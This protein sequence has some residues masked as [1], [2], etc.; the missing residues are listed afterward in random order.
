M[1]NKSLSIMIAAAIVLG[2][3]AYMKS[4]NDAP[5]STSTSSSVA[6]KKLLPALTDATLEGITG[7]SIKSADLTLVLNKT[8]NAWVASS[9]YD[10]PV[11]ISKIRSLLKDLYAQKIG[12]ALSANEEQRR[13]LQLLSP[14]TATPANSADTGTR[15]TLMTGDTELATLLVGKVFATAQPAGPSFGAPQGGGQYVSNSDGAVLLLQKEISEASKTLLDWFDAELLRVPALEIAE[16]SVTG[17]GRKAIT[18]V[19]TPDNGKLTV[20]DLPE[21]KELADNEI[22]NL[23]G[24]L[25]YLRMEG[26]ADPQIDAKISGLDAP[27]T[28]VSHRNNGLV[29]TARIGN[30]QA[31]T[32]N[33]YVQLEMSYKNRDTQK[34]APLADTATDAEKAARKT[35]DATAATERSDLEKEV[36]DF[37]DAHSKWI[38]LISSYKA[39]S[40]LKKHEDLYKEPA[41][42]TPPTETGNPAAPLGPL[43]PLKT[44]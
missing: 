24:A 19:K 42:S 26:V 15:I 40:L 16:L 31:E 17:K 44:P 13:E 5:A 20:S 25:A 1:T 3:L 41:P 18:L 33:R 36:K 10:Y 35:A 27:V 12:Q 32:G 8:E 29:Y 6:G 21:G 30:K 9:S 37:N 34:P 38:Y 23:S 43:G 14:E 11:S 2:G 4:N 28:Y 7:I 39:D 22:S